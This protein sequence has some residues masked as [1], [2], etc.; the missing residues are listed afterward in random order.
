MHAENLHIDINIS[1][2][3]RLVLL[4]LFIIACVGINSQTSDSLI[5]DE[6]RKLVKET[7]AIHFEG[8][9]YS[10]EWKQEARRRG[11]DCETSVPVIYDNYL[12]PE[13]VAMF[14]STNVMTRKELAA[15]NEVKWVTYTKK[16]Q[17]ESRVLGDLAMNHIVP[18]ATKY[19]TLLVENVYKVRTVLPADRAEAATKRNVELIENI[20]A[21]IAF[22]EERVAAMIEARKVANRIAD[23]RQRAVAYHDTVAPMF[24]EIRYH[25]DELELIVS[26]QEWTLPKYRELLFIR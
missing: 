16:I 15:R 23:N 4:I 1:A 5:V 11:L 9:G 2:M 10:E 13:S 7:K 12:K 22:I 21:H 17:I 24:D 14:E 26:D 25:I 20:S 6:L 3:R 18:V 19:Q 8:N